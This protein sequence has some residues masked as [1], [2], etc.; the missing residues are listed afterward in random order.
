MGLPALPEHALIGLRAAGPVASIGV[1]SW[2]IDYGL[3]RGGELLD[4]PW[5]YRDKRTAAGVEAVHAPISPDEL[6]RRTGLQFLP[7]NAI[8]QLAAE[9]RLAEAERR[10]LVPDLVTFALTGQAVCERTNA[11]PG[12]STCAPRDW[13]P[14]LLALVGLSRSQLG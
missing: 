14:E 2:A 5:C 10:L 11:S 6:Y 12:C 1:D 4:L 8:Y 3:V 9:S 7:F 13:A